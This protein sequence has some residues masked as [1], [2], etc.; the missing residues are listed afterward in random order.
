MA[1]FRA[2]SKPLMSI[3]AFIKVLR[4]RYDALK[5]PPNVSDREEIANLIASFS[6]IESWFISKFLNP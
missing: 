4:R 2:L 5:S 1:A 6:L 3:L